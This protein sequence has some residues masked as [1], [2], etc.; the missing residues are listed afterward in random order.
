MANA[1]DGALRRMCREGA[2]FPSLLRRIGYRS[3]NGNHYHAIAVG[4]GP[5]SRVRA[6][7]LPG[8]AAGW[9]LAWRNR[10]T[11]RNRSPLGASPCGFDSHRQHPRAIDRNVR[12]SVG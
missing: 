7:G 5:I 10:Q 6:F 1:R 12:P 8:F 9:V 4:N 3:G 11:R 2:A